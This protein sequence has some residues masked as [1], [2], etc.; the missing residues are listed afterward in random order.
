MNTNLKLQDI[1]DERIIKMKAILNCLLTAWDNYA[2]LDQDTI[3]N[4]L[5]SIDDYLREIIEYKNEFERGASKTNKEE[6]S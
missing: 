5:W 2:T 3:Y 1:I 4:T 6:I